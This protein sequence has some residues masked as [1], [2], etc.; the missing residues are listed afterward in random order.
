[1]FALIAVYGL[2]ARAAGR[3]GVAGFGLAIVGTM[4][5]G[6]DLWFESFAVPWLAEGSGRREN[7]SRSAW[8]APGLM[9]KPLSVQR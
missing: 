3:L 7:A 4:L 2:L 8:S 6:D 5:L 9:P 1:M